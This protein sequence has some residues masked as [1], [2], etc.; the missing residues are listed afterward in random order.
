MTTEQCVA[1]A[2]AR[3]HRARR[4]RYVADNYRP[5]ALLAVWCAWED[6][7]DRFARAVADDLDRNLDSLVA[8]DLAAYRIAVTRLD[9]VRERYLT[10]EREKREAVA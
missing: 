4:N 5:A 2:Y 9:H 7:R 8:E 3:A 1:L 6:V 10:G